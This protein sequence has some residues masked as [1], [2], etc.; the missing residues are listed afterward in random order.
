MIANFKYQILFWENETS[1]VV[2]DFYA[3]HGMEIW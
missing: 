3:P 2:H 1:A